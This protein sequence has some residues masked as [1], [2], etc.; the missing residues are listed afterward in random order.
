MHAIELSVY[1]SIYP[2][3]Q[4]PFHPSIYPPNYPPINTTNHPF[5]QSYIFQVFFH[6]I[7]F[8]SIHLHSWIHFHLSHHYSTHSF[9]HR[10]VH[11]FA[12]RGG[13][14]GVSLHMWGRVCDKSEAVG[15]DAFFTL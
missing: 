14:L 9:I 13:H 6:P 10:P 1:P 3:I 2:S 11:S 4:V 5:L 12:N 8:S 7:L 15:C